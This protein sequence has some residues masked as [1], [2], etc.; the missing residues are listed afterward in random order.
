MFMATFLIPFIHC[1]TNFTRIWI[2]GNPN[3]IA[4]IK[5]LLFNR[6]TLTGDEKNKCLISG[7]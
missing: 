4:I 1:S 2:L 7:H 3:L 5:L 6:F